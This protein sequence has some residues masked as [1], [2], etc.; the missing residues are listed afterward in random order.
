MELGGLKGG[1]ILLALLKIWAARHSEALRCSY[2]A[3]KRV[4]LEMKEN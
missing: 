1:A 3:T 4:C 2:I